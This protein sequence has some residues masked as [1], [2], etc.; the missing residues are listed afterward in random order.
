MSILERPPPLCFFAGSSEKTALVICNFLEYRAAYLGH[1]LGCCAMYACDSSWSFIKVVFSDLYSFQ[2][3]RTLIK[4]SRCCFIFRDFCIDL[5]NTFYLV[6][7]AR[8][9]DSKDVI[10][11]HDFMDFV[12]P[13]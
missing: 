13:R 7:K 1:I 4:S 8:E 12:A 5:N 11:C 2:G 9:M 10:L 6:S 3:V